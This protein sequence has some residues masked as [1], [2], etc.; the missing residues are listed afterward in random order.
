MDS[1]KA[2]IATRFPSVCKN[3]KPKTVSA[4]KN[5]NRKGATQARLPAF[6]RMHPDAQANLLLGEVG[7]RNEVPEGHRIRPKWFP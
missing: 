5:V 3:V 6:P 2:D 7:K 4:G 1:G